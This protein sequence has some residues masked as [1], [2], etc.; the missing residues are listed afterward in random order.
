MQSSTGEAM[1]A[2]EMDWWEDP[3]PDLL[4]LLRK[5][6]ILTPVTDPTGTPFVLRPNHLHP[7]LDNPKLRRALIG[8]F[9]QQECMIAMMGGDTSLW[10]VP[11]GFFP[12]LS[13]MASDAGMGALA[14]KRDYA[15]VRKAL[16]TAGYRG[17][18]LVLMGP[19]DQAALDALSKV[20]FEAL[21]RVGVNVDY[22]ATD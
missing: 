15:A 10:T 11:A 19:T 12:P 13:P 3:T 20:V 7:P 1:Q 14:S 17:E 6:N 22:Q 16:E 2:G 8:A 9:D 5:R 18:K 4:P 21:K